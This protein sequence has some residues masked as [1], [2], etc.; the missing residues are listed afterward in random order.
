MPVTIASTPI[1]MTKTPGGVS[2]RAPLT[3]EDTDRLLAEL[4]LGAEE[5]ADLKTR[6]IVA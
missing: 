5:I 3:G 2:R 1:R 6:R 4:G